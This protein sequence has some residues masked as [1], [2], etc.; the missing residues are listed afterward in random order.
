MNRR[1]YAY[2]RV[3][4]AYIMCIRGRH[5]NTSIAEYYMLYSR[6]IETR[7]LYLWT[8]STTPVEYMQFWVFELYVEVFDGVW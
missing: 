3:F 1:Q 5:D 6:R 8:D 7:Y 4:D 2:L